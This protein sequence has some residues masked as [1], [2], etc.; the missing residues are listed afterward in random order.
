MREKLKEWWLERWRVIDIGFGVAFSTLYVRFT[1]CGDRSIQYGVFCVPQHWKQSNRCWN[2]S[3]KL[4]PYQKSHWQKESQ[5]RVIFW[6]DK[7]KKGTSLL[8]TFYESSPFPKAE[9]QADCSTLTR[10]R[11]KWLPVRRRLR[12]RPLSQYRHQRHRHRSLWTFV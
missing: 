5:G 10:R 3:M 1:I 6:N 2:W 11:S 8:L 7:L 4:N 9:G 12:A